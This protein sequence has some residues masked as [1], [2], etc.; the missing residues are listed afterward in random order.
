MTA[1]GCLDFLFT[2]PVFKFSV[3]NRENWIALATFELTAL[4]VSRLSWKERLRAQEQEYERRGISKLYQLSNAILLV[5]SRTSDLEP[6]A[7]LMREFFS[8]RSVELWIAQDGL[9]SASERDGAGNSSAYQVFASGQDAD[10]LEQGWSKRVLRL[11][12]TPIGGMVLQGWAVAPSLADAAASLLAVAVERA[13]S[14]HKENRAEAARNTEQLRTAVLDAL[15]HGFKTP[16]TAIQTA[17]SGLLAI[18]RLG[19]AQT[20]LVEI[21]DHEVAM[22]A[23]LTTRLLQ[24]AALDAREIRVRSSM[25]SV[26]PLLEAVIA[27]QDSETRRRIRVAS[28]SPLEDVKGDAQLLTLALAQLIDNAAKYSEVGTDIDVTV[29]Q[30]EAKTMVVVRNHGEPIRGEDLSRIFERYFR[31][32]H[33]TRGPTGT[34]LGLSIVKKIAEAHGGGV[35]ASCEG[36]RIT[37]SLSLMG[38]R[39]LTNG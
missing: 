17:S 13:R 7:A 16:L 3:H 18:G 36:N 33:A 12:T 1:V 29:E 37:L 9:A 38:G 26:L 31:G 14:A 34:G 27:E 19:E 2:Q 32:L 11:G 22:L 35:S 15:A 25:I 28:S 24:T 4:L 23:N 8:I 5:D 30:D 10:S 6:L 39:R 21:I 20:E